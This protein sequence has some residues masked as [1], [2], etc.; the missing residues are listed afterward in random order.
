MSP[1]TAS[2]VVEVDLPTVEDRLDAIES[3]SEFLTEVHSLRRLGDERY[4]ADLA[5]GRASLIWVGSEPDRH[6]YRWQ[7]LRGPEFRG[8]ISL[9]AAG[10]SHTLVTL[11]VQVEPRGIIRLMLDM[12]IQSSDAVD[13]DVHRLAQH[14]ATGR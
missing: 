8:Q 6:R 1:R 13:L 4:Q 10:P 7:S 11:E 2:A 12:L 14:V 3:W 9:A 5:D